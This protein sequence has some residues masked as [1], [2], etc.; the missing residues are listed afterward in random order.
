[1]SLPAKRRGRFHKRVTRFIQISSKRVIQN[2][3][4]NTGGEKLADQSGTLLIVV[5]VMLI[6]MLLVVLL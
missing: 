2:L 3:D 5:G 4:T 1:M 6:V